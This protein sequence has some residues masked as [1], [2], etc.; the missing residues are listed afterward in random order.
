MMKKFASLLLAGVLAAGLLA[1]CGSSN[2]P[3]EAGRPRPP[4]RCLDPFSHTP[5]KL[6]TPYRPHRAGC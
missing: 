5:Q 3:A 4:P 1:G 6:H 2:T